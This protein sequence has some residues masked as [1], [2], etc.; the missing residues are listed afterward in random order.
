[1][2]LSPWVFPG[3]NTGVGCHFIFQGI[4]PTQGFNPCLLYYRQI[5]TAEPPGEIYIYKEI[6]ENN[7]MRKTRDL[8]KIIRYTKGTFQAMMGSIKGRNGMDLK[9]AEY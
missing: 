2:L 3:K 7:R 1:M 8:F 5:F 4:I 9:E 6:K